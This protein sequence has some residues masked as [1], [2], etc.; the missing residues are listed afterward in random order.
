MW[1]EI[2]PFDVVLFRDSRPFS[3]GE[4]TRAYGSIFPPSGLPFVGAIRSIMLN[5]KGVAYRDYLDN[6]DEIQKIYG[7][8]DNL[9]PLC[10]RGPFLA[11][12]NQLIFPT[13]RDLVELVHNEE[14]SGRL[15]YLKASDVMHKEFGLSSSPP[16][17]P[18]DFINIIPG[19]REPETGFIDENNLKEYLLE[20]Q[21]FSVWR[22]GIPAVDETRTGTSLNDNGTVEKGMLYTAAFKRMCNQSAFWVHISA[23]NGEDEKLLRENKGFIRLGGERKKADYCRYADNERSSLF[24]EA[25]YTNGLI[26][27]LTGQ[28]NFKL[29]LLTAAV[30]SAGWYPDGIRIESGHYIYDLGNG[31]KA[32]LM[33]A[34]VGKRQ[35][36]GGWNLAFKSPRELRRVVPAGSVYYFQMDEELNED[37][38]KYLIDTFHLKSC[39]RPSPEDGVAEFQR[40]AGF[41]CTAVGV[42]NNG[43]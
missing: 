39:M 30:F 22:E 42:W 6:K 38:A 26:S 5:Q 9:K 17:L 33:S 28:K 21:P 36:I 1:L 11:Y 34:A 43:G 25:D 18:L 24:N 14:H 37:H 2:K 4:N 41:G 15:Q 20:N 10:F 35:E 29:L 40:R 13:P 16:S 23:D 32:T 31:M 8:P 27:H 3:A 19:A 7:S 12:G